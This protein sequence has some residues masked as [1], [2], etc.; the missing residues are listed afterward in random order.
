MLAPRVCVVQP[1]CAMLVQVT[2]LNLTADGLITTPLH[3]M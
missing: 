3:F 1:K 2:Q